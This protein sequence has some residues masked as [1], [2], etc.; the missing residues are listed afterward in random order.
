MTHDFQAAP[1]SVERV[2]IES[3]A[4]AGDHFAD[5]L[6]NHWI[7]KEDRNGLHIHIQGVPEAWIPYW[8]CHAVALP[9]LHKVH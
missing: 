9:G 4:E 7:V 6:G 3:H 1:N 8:T 2:L 5:D